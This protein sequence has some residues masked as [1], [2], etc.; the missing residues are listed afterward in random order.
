MTQSRYEGQW[1]HDKKHGEGKFF[2]LDSGQVLEGTWSENISK[3]GEMSDFNRGSA[4]AATQF[5][6]PELKLAEYQGV[7]AEARKRFSDRSEA[8]EVF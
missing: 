2:Y 5:P 7:L 8:D 4:T 1:A 6:I 3:C